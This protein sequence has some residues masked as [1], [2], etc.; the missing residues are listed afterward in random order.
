MVTV[1][2]DDEVIREGNKEQRS[3]KQAISTK[4]LSLPDVNRKT[5]V[6]GH[7]NT[8]YTGQARVRSFTLPPSCQA[9]KQQATELNTTPGIDWLV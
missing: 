1:F 5:P 6:E 4:Y 7:Q 2:T 3:R 9:N 8:G